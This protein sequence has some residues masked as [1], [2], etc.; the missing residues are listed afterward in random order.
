MNH[1]RCKFGNQLEVG[2]AGFQEHVT[3]SVNLNDFWQGRNSC[4]R[5]SLL[6]CIRQRNPSKNRLSE[7]STCVRERDQ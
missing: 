7:R 2:G 3:E 6:A 5:D 4:G 1:E